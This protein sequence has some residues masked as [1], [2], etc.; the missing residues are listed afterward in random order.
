MKKILVILGHPNTGS[1]CDALF[2]S[3]IK[4]AELRGANIRT[5]KLSELSF[6]PVLWKGYR[7][8]QE[9]EPDL[10]K[11]QQDIQWAEHIAFIY[12]IWWGSIPSLMK[13][14][15]DRIF[16]PGFAFKYRENS[17]LWDKLLSNRTAQL[18]VTMDTPPWYF[19]WV[20]RSPGHNEMKRTILGF[21]GIRVTQIS[22]F[23]PIQS[24]KLEQREKWLKVAE[25]LGQKA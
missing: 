12:P 11:A 19:R 7:E 25:R 23:S 2:N 22:E 13:G 16:L 17:Q 20:Y 4:G 6:D 3:Y 24:S 8:I 15:I 5:I 9:L 14:F 10:I 1:F 18:I 21:S